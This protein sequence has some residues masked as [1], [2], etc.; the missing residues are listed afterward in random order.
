[1][2]SDRAKDYVHFIMADKANLSAEMGYHRAK[3]R[4]GLQVNH[5]FKAEATEHLRISAVYEWMRG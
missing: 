5:Y 1:M 3:G 2:A 4:K